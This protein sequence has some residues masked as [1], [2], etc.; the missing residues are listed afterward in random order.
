MAKPGKLP[1]GK[2]EIPFELP[3]RPKGNKELYETYHGVFVN[4]QVCLETLTSIILATYCFFF[5]SD[6]SDGTILSEYSHQSGKGNS[7][8]NPRMDHPIPPYFICLADQCILFILL[9]F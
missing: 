7:I 2:T 9:F 5:I 4:I 8:L 3:V 6:A 1:A